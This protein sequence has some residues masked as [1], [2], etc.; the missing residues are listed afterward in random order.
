MGACRFNEIC[1]TIPGLTDKM[2]SERLSEFEQEQI[3]IRQV[4][5]EKPVRIE[6]VLT[7]KGRALESVIF[8][9]AEWAETWM[10]PVDRMDNPPNLRT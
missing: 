7:D 8:A 2:L 10:L 4:S 5:S 1:A 9:L 3:V 6:Y